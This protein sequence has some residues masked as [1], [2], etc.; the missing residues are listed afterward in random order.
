MALLDILI[1]QMGEGL[2]EVI[3]VSRQKQPGDFVRRDELLY[4]METDKAVMEVE[5][6]YEGVLQEWLAAEGATLPI[7]APIARIETEVGSPLAPTTVDNGGGTRGGSSF[8]T[9]P[10]LGAGGP[11]SAPIPPRTRAHGR[12]LGLSDEEMGHIPAPTGKLMPAD[13]DAYLAARPKEARQGESAYVE[14]PLSQQ[15]RLFVQRLKRSAQS[16]VPA[17]MKRPLEWSGLS[18]YV[19][20]VRA[21][22]GQLRP[23]EFQ[24]FAWC[25]AQAVRDHPKFRSVLTGEEAAHEYA[26]LN[27][28]IAVARPNGDLVTAV[29]SQADTL[30]FSAFIQTTQARI[31]AAREGEDQATAETQL[32]LTYM[33]AYDVLD[34]VP[35]LVAPAI[36]VLFVGA[37]YEQNGKTL[38]NLVLTFDHR[39]INGVEAAEFLRAAWSEWDR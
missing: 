16:V 18:H 25:V 37:T 17:T 35:V 5:S 30:D 15:Q 33:G 28:G 26:H 8:P 38:A 36:A 29:V 23:T 9:P 3:V 6:P 31:G 11:P 4:S 21:Q 22:G 24:T 34:A 12:E 32:L 19:E 10:L 14:R 27:L 20:A 39:L 13:V 7:G 1:P 2:Q